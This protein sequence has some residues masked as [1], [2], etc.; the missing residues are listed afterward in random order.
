MNKET[1]PNYEQP[2]WK[3]KKLWVTLICNSQAT[4]LATTAFLTQEKITWSLA[5]FM[6]FA[7]FIIGFTTV[8]YVGRQAAVDSLVR[9]IALL[10]EAPQS[11][12]QQ[13][14]CAVKG[15]EPEP[16]DEDTDV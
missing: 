3:S 10:K 16:K 15:Y 12:V 13:V 11:F 7:L 5:F 1:N 4:G 8:W 6:V 9:G 2:G 14:K